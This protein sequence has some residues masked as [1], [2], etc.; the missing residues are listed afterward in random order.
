MGTGTFIIVAVVIAIIVLGLVWGVCGEE[1]WRGIVGKTCET[2]LAILFIV[3]FGMAIADCCRRNAF[4]KKVNV[5]GISVNSKD[6]EINSILES[7]KA[8]KTSVKIIRMPREKARRKAYRKDE[9]TKFVCGFKDT[10]TGEDLEIIYNIKYIPGD[11][12]SDPLF[13]SNIKAITLYNPQGIPSTKYNIDKEYLI[14]G[15]KGKGRYRL[16]IN[17]TIIGIRV[18]DPDIFFNARS[19]N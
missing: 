17:D 16:T 3:I 9:S 5:Y 12:Y 8:E 10:V 11:E 13:A 6:S 2:I 4:S 7:I 19:S 15:K 14:N 18:I 1:G